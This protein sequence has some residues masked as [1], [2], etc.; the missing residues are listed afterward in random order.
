[1]DRSGADTN[2]IVCIEELKMNLLAKSCLC[3][4]INTLLSNLISS[5]GDD[6]VE[7]TDEWMNEYMEGCGKEIYRV[8]LSPIFEGVTFLEV[9][10]CRDSELPHD[11]NV[12]YDQTYHQGAI[13]S[14]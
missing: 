8:D 11:W 7:D 6:E 3:P 14:V 2:H 5:M 1:M 9:I 13:T 4:G 12:F 10:N